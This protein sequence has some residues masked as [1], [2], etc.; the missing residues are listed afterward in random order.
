MRARRTAWWLPTGVSPDRF[1]SRRTPRRPRSPCHPPRA[2]VYGLPS[3]ISTMT[4]RLFAYAGPNGRRPASAFDRSRS[5]LALEAR[6]WAQPGTW[7]AR[8]PA[9]GG[10]MGSRPFRV[11]DGRTKAGMKEERMRLG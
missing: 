8:T 6:R 11:L 10:G 9:T 7:R 1:E 3:D 2:Q 5:D 4:L